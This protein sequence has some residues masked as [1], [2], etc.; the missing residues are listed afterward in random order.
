MKTF[1]EYLQNV[2]AQEYHGT[3]DNMPDAF[4]NWVASLDV[5]EVIEY[6]EA[7]GRTIQGLEP[8][9]TP[10]EKYERIRNK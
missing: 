8:E 3:D 1:E 5:D 6:A 9:E 10:Q 4:D 2:H 7:W